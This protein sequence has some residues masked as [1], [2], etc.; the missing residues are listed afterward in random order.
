MLRL[1][2]SHSE[3]RQSVG[4]GCLHPLPTFR[5]RRRRRRRPPPPRS[6]CTVQSEAQVEERPAVVLQ[7]PAVAKGTQ[8]LKRRLS[9]N[10][11]LSGSQKW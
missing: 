1:P 5:R 3:C 7:G 11:L 9:E 2:H 8:T 6:N 10:L 4:R